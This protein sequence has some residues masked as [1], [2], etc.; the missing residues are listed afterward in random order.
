MKKMQ[1][2]CL[3]ETF[4]Q[5]TQN[6]T[7]IDVSIPQPYFLESDDEVNAYIQSLNVQ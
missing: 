6:N 5:S 1:N 7:K 2:V 3:N 4:D